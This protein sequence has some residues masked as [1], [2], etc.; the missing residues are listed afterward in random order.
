MDIYD[1]FE[2]ESQCPCIFFNYNARYFINP[3]FLIL[4]VEHF[5]DNYGSG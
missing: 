1:N 4:S 3:S 2:D 5:A